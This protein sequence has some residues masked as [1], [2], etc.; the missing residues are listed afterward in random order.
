M[1]RT[2][3]GQFSI[4]F[5]RGWGQWQKDLPSLIQWAKANAFEAIDLGAGPAED[6]KSVVAAGLR[7]GTTDLKGWSDLG[8]PDAGKRAEAVALNAEHIKATVA[9]G[10]KNFFVLLLPPDPSKP[11]K[12]N[13]ANFVAGYSALCDAVK[14][15]GARLAIEGWPGGSPWHGAIACTPADYREFLKQ[16]GSPVMAIN[17]DPSHLIRVGVDPVRFLREFAPQ[18]VHVHG[19]DTEILD[20]ELYEHGNLQPATFAQGHGFGAHHWRYTIPG[21]GCAHW[22]KMFS[23]LKDAGFSGCVCIELEDERYNGTDEGDKKGFIAG[24]QFLESV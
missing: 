1:A 22:T 24:R 7:V 4:G 10:C 16:V 8:S 21:H 19:K 14:S 6:V 3:T 9:A 17:F 5:R 15:T 18:V 2:S 23:I 11:R 12:E 20:D 13:F